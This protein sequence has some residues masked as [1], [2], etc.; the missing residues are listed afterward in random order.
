MLP[1]DD[2]VSYWPCFTNLSLAASWYQHHSLYVQAALLNDAK[3]IDYV[4]ND[5]PLDT[6]ATPAFDYVGDVSS[7]IFQVCCVHCGLIVWTVVAIAALSM[8]AMMVLY[9]S[10]ATRHVELADHGP[11][12]FR[13]YSCRYMLEPV[14]QS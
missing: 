10:K 1:C 6:D 12:R 9:D 11:I 7:T 3:I 14:G 4:A 13:R 8:T 5:N 2:L